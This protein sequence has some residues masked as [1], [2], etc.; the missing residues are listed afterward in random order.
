MEKFIV[1][2]CEYGLVI[3]YYGNFLR[4]LLIEYT[5]SFLKKTLHGKTNHTLTKIKHIM[6]IFP[7]L[8]KIYKTVDLLLS[9]KLNEMHG[10]WFIYR[11]FYFK[12]IRYTLHFLRIYG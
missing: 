2:Y 8:K 10:I 1:T 11:I 7:Y 3:T 12:M 6:V 9:S 5:H 4:D